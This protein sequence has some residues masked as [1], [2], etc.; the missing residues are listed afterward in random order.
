MHHN[1]TSKDDPSPEVSDLGS[2]VGY[3]L[4]MVSNQVTGE[5]IRAI[6]AVGVS[7]SEWVTL[8][9]LWDR[10]SASTSDIINALGMT[11][12]G[13]S[14]VISR[15]EEKGL[16]RR[17]TDD[18]DG[19]AQRVV[20]TAEGRDLVPKL[21]EIADKNDAKFFGHLTPQET[22]SIVQAMKTIV[23]LQQIRVV[24]VD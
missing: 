5:F 14:K 8:R 11:K 9:T 10:E 15:L 21:A 12:G 18:A 22:Q 24:P 19:R 16:V 6:E 4:R 3:W 17:L 13:A 2:H 1:R 20:L 7:A 23:H